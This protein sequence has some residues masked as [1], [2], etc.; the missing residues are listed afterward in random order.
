VGTQISHASVL[1]GKRQVDILVS[2]CYQIAFKKRTSMAEL[3]R[4]AASE[5]IE[6]DED[7]GEGGKALADEQGTLTWSEYF[8]KRKNQ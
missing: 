1:P 6:D 8:E 5:V 7:L 2:V 3:L 4:G